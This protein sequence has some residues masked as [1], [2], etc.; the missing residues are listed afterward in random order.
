[1][2]CATVGYYNP[3]TGT[4]TTNYL[5]AMVE[6]GQLVKILFPNGGWLDDS[7]FT[8]PDIDSDGTCSFITDRGYR[9]SVTLSSEGPCQ[10]SSGGS[11]SSDDEDEDEE[12]NLEE[13]YGRYKAEVVKRFSGCDYMILEESGD[14]HVVE[15]MGSYDPDEGDQVQGNFHSYGNKT[16]YV[17][18]RDR[19]TRLWIEDYSVSYSRAME[20]IREKCNLEDE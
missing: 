11:G 17:S 1:L 6:N 9:M 20:I 2:Y 8:P 19:E 7:H 13:K 15:W 12:A 16:C 5:T 10:Y 14:Y 4:S 3:N 18:R